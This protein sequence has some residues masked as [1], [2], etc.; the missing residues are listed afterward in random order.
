MGRMLCQLLELKPQAT[1]LANI[2]SACMVANDRQAS[3]RYRKSGKNLRHT[4][5]TTN[6]YLEA[7]ASR[8]S[9]KNL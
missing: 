2:D 5:A 6:G 1:Y 4:K 7:T 3:V 9:A 8:S